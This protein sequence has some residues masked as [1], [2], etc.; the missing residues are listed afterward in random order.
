MQFVKAD[1]KE[2]KQNWDELVSSQK[3]SIFSESNYLDATAQQWFI[4]YSDDFKSG[5]ACPF[6]V[7]G[8][9]KILVTPFF[10]RF[11]EWIGNSVSEQEIISALKSKFPVADLQVGRGFSLNQRIYQKLETGNLNLNQQAKRSLNKSKGFQIDRKTNIPKMI[12]LLNQELAHKIHGINPE[13]L[14]I[15][16]VLVKKYS[17]SKLRQFNLM[18]ENKWLGAIW[19][20]ETDSSILY[21]KG[22]TTDEAKKM[23]GMYRLIHTGIEYAHEQGK[24]FDFGGSNAE[25]VRRFNLNFGAEDVV[26]SQLSWNNGPFW[27]KTIKMIRDKWTKK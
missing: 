23:G 11:M 6:V 8:G 17:E 1:T 22:T 16:E 10:N 20:L 5:M 15:L 3:G 21:L 18:Q 24:I 27:W 9:I 19:I 13:T 7:K 14:S 2:V 26:Y 4:L 12:Q 25:S